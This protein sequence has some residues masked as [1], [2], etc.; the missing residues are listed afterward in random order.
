MSEKMPSP[1]AGALE[2]M[3]RL[4]RGGFEAW[5]VG[6]CVRDTLL[7]RAPH[8]WDICTSAT[9]EQMRL[10]FAGLHLI[11]T[12]LRHGTLTARVDHV[13]Y[14]VTTYR[15]DGVY[16]DGRRPEQVRF[17]DS[18]TQDLARRDFTINAMAWH[19]L[20]GLA[21]PWGGRADLAARRIRCVGRPADRFEEDALRILRALRFAATL[22]FELEE[23]TA[24]A[25]HEKKASLRRVAPE[26]LREE[27]FRL[28]CGPSSAAVLDDYL[29][30]FCVFVP[31]LGPMK[32]FLQHNSYHDR[33]VW[34]HTLAALEAAPADEP[35]VRLA[36]LLHDVGKPERFTQDADGVGHFYG[37][38]ARSAE[39]AHVL[40][41]RLHCDSETLRT[42]TELV[43]RHDLP[44]SADPRLLRRRL[45]QLGQ[46]QLERLLAL[47]R[48]D[49]CGQA[50]ACRAQR[51]A[52]LE[53]AG[54][55]LRAV[56]AQRPCLGLRQLAVGGRDLL[57]LGIPQG[58][59]VGALLRGLLEQ[60]LDGALPNEREAL[61]AELRKKLLAER[62]G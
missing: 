48:A 2:L 10:C 46:R 28:L 8:D 15:V 13:S 31:E 50:P 57:A 61:L 24:L 12:G 5:A 33:D 1:P 11:D 40:L 25:V 14:E 58:P 20:R 9:P 42:V 32:G 19:P 23:Q 3:E 17:V 29:D 27:F 6:G 62:D 59:R 4:E 26:R 47:Q 53:Q 56:A 38:A 34:G 44:L 18:V 39:I 52:A 7:G 60:V 45:A 49:V 51:L 35:E 41:R 21:D 36:A 16:K 37:H 30:V 54:A 22:G 43:L 55:A